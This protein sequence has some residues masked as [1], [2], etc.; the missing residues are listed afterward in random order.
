MIAV[1][2]VREIS[3]TEIGDTIEIGTVIGTGNCL[4]LFWN[5]L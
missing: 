1:Q 2:E 3:D 4:I 5:S